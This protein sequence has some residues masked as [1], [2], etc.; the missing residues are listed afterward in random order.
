GVD[1]FVAH[2]IDPAQR[3][4]TDAVDQLRPCRDR[5]GQHQQRDKP[6]DT[7]LAT[8]RR[9]L[10]QLES[11]SL[12]R[13]ELSTAFGWSVFNWVADVACLACAAYAAGGRASVAGLTV[14]YAAARAAGTL[15]LMPGGLLVVEAVLVPGL[16]SSGMTLPDAISAVLIYRMISWLLVSAV[17]WVVSTGLSR[18]ALT[19]HSA[20]TPMPSISSG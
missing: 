16:V 14:A 2:R 9:L 15:P 6:V 20:R 5:L 8:W 12:G 4:D 3:A 11:V 17:G 18:T 1:G 19:Q 7:G 10:G 13:R